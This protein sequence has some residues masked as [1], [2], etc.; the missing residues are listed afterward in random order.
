MDFEEKRNFQE[1]LQDVEKR[2]GIVAP[3]ASENCLSLKLFPC[4]DYRMLNSIRETLNIFL[5]N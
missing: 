4:E 2:G 5:Q 1:I 3:S